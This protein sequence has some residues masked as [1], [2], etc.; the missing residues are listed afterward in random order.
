MLRTIVSRF[1]LLH[2]LTRRILGPLFPD[3]A[4][5]WEQRYARGWN[6]GVGSYGRLAEFKAQVLNNFCSSERGGLSNRIRL[7]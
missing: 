7:W 6:S 5:Y 2:P 3:S 1:T 4:T